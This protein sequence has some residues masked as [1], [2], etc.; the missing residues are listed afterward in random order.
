MLKIRIRIS[1]S[2]AHEDEMT[3]YRLSAQHW[4]S[5]HNDGSVLTCTVLCD[6]LGFC[7]TS[8]HHSSLQWTMGGVALW[9]Y[10]MLSHRPHPSLAGVSLSTVTCIRLSRELWCS[11]FCVLFPPSGHRCLSVPDE[12]LAGL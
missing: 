8:S 2:C 7:Q 12:L 1:T 4:G 6:K 3:Q 10:L 5:Q 11:L 9:G